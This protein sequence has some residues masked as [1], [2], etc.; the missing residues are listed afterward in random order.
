VIQ[1]VPGQAL[2]ASA[3]PSDS[4]SQRI[5]YFAIAADKMHPL[6]CLALGG[7]DITPTAQ[8]VSMM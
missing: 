2:R 6:F 8:A 3:C 4:S 1:S 5:D 7:L